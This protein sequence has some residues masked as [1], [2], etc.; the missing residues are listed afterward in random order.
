MKTA[1]MKRDLISR[2]IVDKSNFEYITKTGVINGTLLT[3]IERVMEKYHESRMK[4]E[5]VKFL[6]QLEESTFY[7]DRSAS[8]IINHYLATRKQLTPPKD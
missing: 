2:I 3:E 8:D 5:L 6:C 1:S 7:S 4:E